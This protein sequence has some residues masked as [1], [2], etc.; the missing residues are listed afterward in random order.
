MLYL[1]PPTFYPGL[2][3]ALHIKLNH[4]SKTQMLRLMSRHFYCAGQARIIEEI[5]TSC[6][7]CA[8][9]RE[10]PKE[11]FT[12]STTINPVFGANFS[13]DVIKKDSQLV[14]LCREKLSQF[15]F[16]RII[17]DESADSLRDAIVAAVLDLM[18]ETGANVQVDCAPGLQTLAAETKLDGSIL[19]K[20]GITIDLGR[21]H[22]VNRY[23]LQQKHQH[24]KMNL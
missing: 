20:L 18:P 3:Q 4:P 7:L 11:L 1:S 23:L 9:L 2:V 15:T 22:N 8:S 24:Q 19:K 17:S 6:T 5:S 10:L 13:A 16:T 12:Q 21:V 14:F